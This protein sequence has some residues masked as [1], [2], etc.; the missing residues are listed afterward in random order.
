MWLPPT[1]ACSRQWVT[2]S[3]APSSF[4]AKKTEGALEGGKETYDL[5]GSEISPGLDRNLLFVNRLHQL[6]IEVED[7]LDV[8]KESAGPIAGDVSVAL[9]SVDELA[10]VVLDALFASA[11]DELYEIILLVHEKKFAKPADE[12]ENDKDA[13]TD[14]ATCS[15]YVRKVQ[16]AILNLKNH[17]LAPLQCEMF[18]SP[19]VREL[20]QS[21]MNLFVRHWSLIDTLDESTSLRLAADMAQVEL[22]LEQLQTL[23]GTKISELGASYRAM[24]AFRPLLFLDTED[25]G[26]A[27]VIG[28]SLPYIIVLQHLFSRGPKGLKRP[29]ELAGW[30]PDIYSKW[31]DTHTEHDC[32]KGVQTALAAFGKGESQGKSGSVPDVMARL[33]ERFLIEKSKIGGK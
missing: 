23:A 5:G 20:M 4:T 15:S 17:V 2:T 14:S 21:I 18:L 16:D 10:G 13:G 11:L 28:Q 3:C 6:H 25:V 24:R 26:T 30:S 22:A 27:E 9:K 12:D 8:N 33:C 7:I 29:H 32:I 1:R 31:M 19:R